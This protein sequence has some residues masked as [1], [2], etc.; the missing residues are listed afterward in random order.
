MDSDTTCP[1]PREGEP[2]SRT[3]RTIRQTRGGSSGRGRSVEREQLRR[4]MVTRRGEFILIYTGLLRGKSITWLEA[5]AVLV[6]T[7][8]RA[9]L[10]PISL[11]PSPFIPSSRHPPTPL[12]DIFLRLSPSLHHHHL[13]H[14]PQPLVVQ[15]PQ[16]PQLPCRLPNR[17]PLETAQ[18]QGPRGDLRDRSETGC[19]ERP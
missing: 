1:Y 11:P 17:P 10:S 9:D 13:L 6:R 8:G 12:K 5:A 7:R 2:P 15:A 16:V 19:S 18:T 3:T 14:V 4:R